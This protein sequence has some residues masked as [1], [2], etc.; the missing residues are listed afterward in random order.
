[1]KRERRLILHPRELESLL[2]GE[3]TMVLRIVKWKPADP[4]RSFNPSFSGLQVGNYFTGH[5]SSGW[6]LRSRGAS[7]CWEDRSKPAHCPLGE[8][9]DLLW[10]PE[11][12]GIRNCGCR[13]SLDPGHWTEGLPD[14]RL[15]YASDEP[16]SGWELR[17]AVC[18]PRWAARKLLEVT[19][20]S[21]E[22][23]RRSDAA[24]VAGKSPEVNPWAW[25]VG[26]REVSA[27]E[28]R[29]A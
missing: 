23:L 6:V 5:P 3:L 28:A 16:I 19:R 20:V 12:W 14:H 11:P 17:R 9:G 1:M 10:V 27:K 13:V 29:A 24:K 26:V 25:A 2:R 15:M 22:W 21:V 8:P 4:R 7:S 18:M